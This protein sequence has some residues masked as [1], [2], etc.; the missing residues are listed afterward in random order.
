[1]DISFH[2]HDNQHQ[3]PRRCSGAV[4]LVARY[5]VTTSLRAWAGAGAGDGG[6]C[7]AV[8][9]TFAVK[10]EAA[11]PQQ[12]PRL[13]TAR[14]HHTLH[15]STST[16]TLANPRAGVCSTQS[17]LLIRYLQTADCRGRPRADGTKTII[18][19]ATQRRTAPRNH[20]MDVDTNNVEEENSDEK[21]NL[22]GGLQLTYTEYYCMLYV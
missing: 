4:E 8:L 17:S 19:P 22:L 15:R 18:S 1:M 21:S 10:Q 12:S 13:H 11:Q 6:R 9:M 14:C 20:T 16:A 7:A 2:I 3:S 5:N